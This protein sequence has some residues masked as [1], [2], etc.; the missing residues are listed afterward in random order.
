MCQKAH[1]IIGKRGKK[2]VGVMTS[3]EKGRN[4]TVVCCVSASGF[5]VPPLFIY[6]RVRVSRE[7][8]DRGPVG[9][10]AVGSKTGWITEDIFTAWF[11]HFWNAVQPK[12]RKIPTLL[13]VD[14][15]VSH[16]NNLA[17]IDMAREN[18]VILIIFPSHC[19]HKLQPLDVT[20][21]ESLKWNYDKEV[22][23]RVKELTFI[24]KD[25]KQSC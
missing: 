6:P 20:I 14:M 4:V 10:V 5:Y 22:G 7:F 1:K 2:N 18:N 17:V 8:L 13:L 9:S 16:T 25:L 3:V 19:T 12:N 11:K 15:Y 21:F 24:N 23:L